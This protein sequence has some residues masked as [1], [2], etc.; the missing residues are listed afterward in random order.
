MMPILLFRIRNKQQVTSKL[1]INYDSDGIIDEEVAL[2]EAEN[3]EI[4]N[5]IINEEKI[6]K[7][8]LFSFR[9]NK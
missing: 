6:E 9:K 7:K 3:S 8:K 2:H 5:E 4:E 1:V